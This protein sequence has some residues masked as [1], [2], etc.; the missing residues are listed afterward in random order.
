MEN[1]LI[2]KN[3]FTPYVNFNAQTKI[4]ELTGRCI[5]ED[6]HSFFVPLI[7]WIGD[8][9]EGN[10]IDRNEEYFL[11]IKCDYYN[12]ASA[13]ML[14]YLFDKVAEIQ[15][16]GYNLIVNWHC[17]MDDPDLIDSVND[18]IAMTDVNIIIK[19]I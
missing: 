2:E 18:Y 15:K 7:Q 11:E 1:I 13:K 17:E 4:M 3:E 19:N 6:S 9:F 10:D 12:S 14:V 5:P 8:L 16:S